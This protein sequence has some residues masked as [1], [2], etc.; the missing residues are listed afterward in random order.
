M[1]SYLYDVS[2]WLVV[3]LF[4]TAAVVGLVLIRYSMTRGASRGEQKATGPDFRTELTLFQKLVEQGKTSDAVTQTFTQCFRKVCGVMG[5]DGRA[6]TARELLGSGRLSK[7]IAV[8]LSEMY[9]VYEPVRYGLIPP[10]TENLERFRRSLEK[11]AT[12]IAGVD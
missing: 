10:T 5:V 1:V 4:L 3:N 12:E 6:L 8:F 9:D 2:F 7:N 11:L